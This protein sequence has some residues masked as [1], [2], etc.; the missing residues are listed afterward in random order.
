MR[1]LPG[2]LLAD[3]SVVDY[4][5]EVQARGPCFVPA[6]LGVGRRVVILGRRKNLLGAAGWHKV[7]ASQW[8]SVLPAQGV[9][10]IVRLP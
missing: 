5:G 6:D 10:C 2:S 1:P 8:P 9:G 7:P 3:G 4:R